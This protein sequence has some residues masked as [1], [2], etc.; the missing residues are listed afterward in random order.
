MN[1]DTTFPEQSRRRTRHLESVTVETLTA[2]FAARSPIDI[3]GTL[4]TFGLTGLAEP[5]SYQPQA[6]EL[7]FT[8]SN[9]AVS[10]NGALRLGKD[11]YSGEEMAEQAVQTIRDIAAGRLPPGTCSILRM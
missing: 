2:V 9:G 7:T 3:D 11:R 8:A 1:G 5:R 10:H 4:Y 6:M